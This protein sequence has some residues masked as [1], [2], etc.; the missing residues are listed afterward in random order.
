MRIGEWVP[1]FKRTLPIPQRLGMAFGLHEG[2]ELN[3]VRISDDETYRTHGCELMVSPI[4]VPSW[5]SVCRLSLRLA[6]KPRSLA[7]ATE[8]LRE[9]RV[10]ILLSECCSTYQQR[11]HWDAICD[12]SLVDGFD[13]IRDVGRGDYAGSMQKFLDILTTGFSS[14]MEDLDHRFAFLSGGAR[15]VQFSPLTGLNDSSF[16]CELS[17]AVV[18]EHRAGAIT[19]PDK[20]AN[21]VSIQCHMPNI[22][23]L[24]EYAMITGNTEQ[25]YLRVLFLRDYENMFR[26]VL[27]DD[28][29]DFAGGGIGLLNRLLNALPHQINLIHAT[30]H[31]FARRDKVAKGRITLTGHWN[32]GDYVA[33]PEVRHAVAEATFKQIIDTLQVEDIDGRKHTSALEVVD[34]AWPRTV[35]PQVFISYST[36]RE[37]ERLQYL[38]TALLQHQFQP[39]LGTEDRD[40][41]R[42]GNRPVAPDPVQSSFQ[43]VETC[44]ASIS[45]QVKRDDFKIVD[46]LTGHAR[47]IVPPWAVAEEVFAWSS[48]SVGMLIRLKD[49]EVE[50]PRYNRNI[51]TEE[52]HGDADYPAA[53]AAVLEKLDEFRLNPRFEQLR[54]EAR[55]KQFRNVYSPASY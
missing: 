55:R 46:P 3:V 1:V 2:S 33:P 39:V 26:V 25:R 11:A 37:E 52:F 24:P 13:S 22:R 16:I 6:D 47:Y 38:M 35:Y 9:R 28:L 15:F 40:G 20:L 32:P 10:N 8:F 42:I 43:A 30:N 14:F 7:V 23:A 45:L 34:F 5:R 12:L 29:T 48:S 18:L 4:P 51:Y 54:L 27:N 44:I 53:V 31:I 19:L 41:S 50:D 36:K 49:A 21:D 17:E